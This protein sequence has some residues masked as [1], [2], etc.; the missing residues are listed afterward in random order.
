MVIGRIL[1]GVNGDRQSVHDPKAML[2]AILITAAFY[3]VVTNVPE[4]WQRAFLIWAQNPDNWP[5][6]AGYL[7]FGLVVIV[8]ITDFRHFWWRLLIWNPVPR[9]KKH[10]TGCLL[11]LH[12]VGDH[13]SGFHWL[14]RELCS[15][16]GN[17]LGLQQIKVVLPDAPRRAVTAAGHKLKAWFD[18]RSM[19]ITPEELVDADGLADAKK[20]VQALIKDQIEAGI[21]SEKIILGGFSQ[22]AAVAAWAAAECPHK[23]GGVVLWSGY[24]PQTKELEAALKAGRNA[25]GTPFQCGHGTADSKIK[26][27]CG[28]QLAQTLQAAGVQLDKQKVFEGLDHGCVREQLED[29]AT[30]FGKIA[31][32][33]DAPP[34]KS[35]KSKKAEKAD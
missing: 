9:T 14:R 12:G 31:P 10:H 7:L 30:L 4:S 20:R 17:G 29:M 2:K 5:W 33:K 34:A 26:M 22:G 32:P 27:E 35:K 16:R 24:A 3:S 28:Q 6:L 13:G 18:V 1:L 8:N 25:K 15:T 19:P 23:L 11:W 21:P